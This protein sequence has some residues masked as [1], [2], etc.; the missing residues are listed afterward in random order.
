MAVYLI[1]GKLGTGKG[2]T[3][4]R[5]IKRYL[6]EGR[7]VAT[8]MDIF[9]EHLMLPQ[10]KKTLIR[11]PDKPAVS[12]F[13]LIGHG[14]PDSYDES[15]NGAI[16]LDELGTWLNARTFN[17]KARQAVIDW[18]VHSR[19]LGWDLYLTCQSF[20]AI[21]KQVRESVVEYLIRCVRYDKHRIPIIGHVL[22]TFNDDWGRLPRFHKAATYM[23]IEGGVS[24]QSVDSDYFI[25]DDLHKA[26]D[27]RQIFTS[28]YPHGCHS[29]L[30]AWHLL[31]RVYVRPE[32]PFAKWYRSFFSGSAKPRGVAKPLLPLVA[33]LANLPPAERIK[34]WR[35]LAAAGAI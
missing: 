22:S 12:D 6:K 17:D 11:M 7:R 4:A 10:S 30:S 16:V 33:K 21:D 25:G 31:G 3:A 20:G 32:S 8:N 5:T 14:N 18:L 24:K 35:R 15:K 23:V 28:Q 2:K 19:K 27:T 1:S 13:E 34:H 29:M 26:Y 9:M